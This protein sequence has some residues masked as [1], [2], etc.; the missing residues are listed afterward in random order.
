[1]YI[2]IFIFEPQVIARDVKPRFLA[3]VVHADFRMVN[4]D[5]LRLRYIE[6]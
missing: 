6:L 5:I 2:Y 4:V 3:F 1:M